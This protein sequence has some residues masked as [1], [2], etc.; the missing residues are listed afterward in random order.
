MTLEEESYEVGLR[1]TVDRA[2]KKYRDMYAQLL[3]HGFSQTQIESAMGAL[4]QVS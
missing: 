4:P 1:M 3:D 2:V